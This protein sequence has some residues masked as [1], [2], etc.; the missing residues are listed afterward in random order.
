MEVMMLFKVQQFPF[1]PFQEIES[2]MDSLIRELTGGRIGTGTRRAPAIEFT[3]NDSEYTVIA[4]LPGLTKEDVKVSLKENELTI[5][6]ERKKAALPENA[7]WIRNEIPFGQFSRTLGFPGEIDPAGCSA[8]MTNGILIISV[9][10]SEKMKPHE[11][12]VQ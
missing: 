6:G 1:I 4:E 8:E 9:P 10:K 5:S 12:K 7:R 2:G 3:E 11:I